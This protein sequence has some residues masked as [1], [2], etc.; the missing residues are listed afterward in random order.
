MASRYK[1]WYETVVRSE[2]L[3][4][5]QYKNVH[6]IPRVLKVS[7]SA[8]TNITSG[9]L[10]HPVAGAFALELISGQ[11]PTLTR[12]RTSNSRYKVRK[13]FLEGAKVILQGEQMY[14]FMDRLVTQVM[15]RIT[16][17]NGLKDSF[18]GHG[19]FALGIRDWGYFPEIE[20]Q[21][22]A[23]SNFQMSSARG[24][25]VLIHTSAE[26]DAEAKLL[27]SAMRFPFRNS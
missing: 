24:I 27:L 16:E 2:L 19:N 14:D 1:L 11:A 17:F 25:G 23:L 5:M 7:L 8:S 10:N 4:K 18:D 3:A 22:T 13:G 20:A 21:Q 9:G 26:S 12:V 6:Q 15:P